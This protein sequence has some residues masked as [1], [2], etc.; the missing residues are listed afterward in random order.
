MEMKEVRLRL[1]RILLRS[2]L[3]GPGSELLDLALSISKSQKQLD[4]QIEDAV[5]SL[6]N[7]ASLI[8]TLESEVK[9]RADR[10]SELQEEHKRLTSLSQITAEQVKALATQIEVSIG[11]TKRWDW[12]VSLIIN[13]IAGLII[14]VLGILSSDWVKQLFS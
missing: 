12:L 3:F 11:K 7:S 5:E 10:L 13:L 9:S 6:R 14:F 8:S 2:V 1:G 4:V